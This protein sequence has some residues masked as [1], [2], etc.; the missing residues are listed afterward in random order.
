[1]WKGHRRRVRHGKHHV[2]G[3]AQFLCTVHVSVGDR[4]GNNRLST[5]RRTGLVVIMDACGPR[6]LEDIGKDT[7]PFED[8]TADNAADRWDNARVLHHQRHDL[9]WIACQREELEIVLANELSEFL[10][11]R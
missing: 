8:T 4:I 11:R 2:Q 6:G 9:G 5:K 7:S 10:V 1:M 3:N